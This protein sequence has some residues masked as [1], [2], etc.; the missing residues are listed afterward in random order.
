MY[1][2]EVKVPGVCPHMSN[3]P[4]SSLSKMH[5]K[6]ENIG[7]ET[8]VWYAMYAYKREMLAQQELKKENI[9]N[10]IP[11]R[12]TLKE[13]KGRK[14]RILAPSVSNLIFVHATSAALTEFKAKHSYLQYITQREGNGRMLLVVPDNQMQEFIRV[15]SHYEEDLT[16]YKPEEICLNRGDKV[17]VHG[18]VFD[19]VEGILVKVKGKRSKRIVI[20]IPGIMAVAM[21]EIEPELIERI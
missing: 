21:A 18:G 5:N 6:E 19:G 7:K 15:A 1:C 11:M 14:E 3:P 2:I 9:E 8:C 10:F 12:Y 16:Y 20:Q 4:I 13:Q 17:R